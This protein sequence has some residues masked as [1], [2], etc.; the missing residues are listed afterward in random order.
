MKLDLHE[1]SKIRFGVYSHE[2][3]VNLS[4]VKL[5][6]GKKHGRGTVYDPLMG[7]IGADLCGTCGHDA[8]KC[9][10]IYAERVVMMR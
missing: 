5:T 2:E 10:Q 3:I 7:A 8:I 9:P 4:V 6:S 1:I